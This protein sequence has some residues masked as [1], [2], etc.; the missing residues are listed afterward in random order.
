MSL[1]LYRNKRNFAQTPE[2]AGSDTRQSRKTL[3]FVVQQHH[4]RQMHYD[5]RLELDGVLK[6]WAVPK[7]P[8]MNPHEHH[9]AIMTE[10]HPLAYQK[11]EGEIPEGNYGA[12]KVIIWDAGTY[13]PLHFGGED[14]VRKGIKKGH[15]TFFLHGKKLNGE[16]ALIKF[17]AEK[18]AWLLIKKGDSAATTADITKDDKSIISGV[19]VEDIG[20]GEQLK[21]GKA[22]MPQNVSPML[23]TLVEK[24]LDKPDWLFEIKWDGYRAIGAKDGDNVQLYSRNQ[25][26]FSG[27]FPD[28]VDALHKLKDNVV[29]DGEV[30]V[31]DPQGTPHFEWLQSWHR[32][33]QGT[34]YYYVF[35][36]LWHNG[37]DV[38][39][40]PLTERKKLLRTLINTHSALRYSDHLQNTGT[41]LFEQAQKDGLEG[42]VAK[43]ADSTYQPGVRGNDWLKI[44]THQR[45]EAVIVGFTDP[46]GSRQYIGS[47][48]L[49]V[50]E[51]GKL[52]YVGHSGGGIPPSQLKSLH[53]RLKKLEQK[54]SPLVDPPK[55]GS[56]THWVKP[57]LVCESNFTE[58]TSS[59]QMRHPSFVGLREDK[60]PQKV[61]REL[62]KRNLEG[63][64]AKAA[65]GDTA[66]R[67][68][69]G[70]V[71]FTHLSKVFWPEHGYTKGDLIAYYQTVGKTMLRYLKDRP[72][73]LN[74]QPHGYQDAGFFQKDVNFDLPK[75]AKVKRIYSESTK[76]NVNYLV[77]SNLDT[78]L[79]MAQLG[80]IEINPWNSRLA[81]PDKPDWAVIDLDPEAVSFSQVVKVAQVVGQVCDKWR[82]PAYPK[83][84]GKTGIHIFIPLNA[85]YTYEQARQFA[86]LI[87]TEVN[88]RLPK[89]TSLERS[90]EKRQG[91]VYLDYLQNSRG[92]TLAAAYSARPTKDA[93]VSA[94]LKWS[95]VNENLKPTDF[96]IK[97]MPARLK[98][99]GDLWR[100]VLGRG[101]N[102]AAVIKRIEKAG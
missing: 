59:G 97:N 33:P 98:K 101:V 9:L 24:A 67:V 26:D 22:K 72:E 6:S 96:T 15:L 55:T 51:H 29:L 76:E 7:G 94:P 42:I 99:V 88:N 84:T 17:G 37:R 27:K 68:R 48:V 18:D 16:F 28:V 73:S 46:K 81:K 77:A 62:P 12:G 65:A 54:A 70:K 91:K 57:E 102:I 100:G 52:V 75:F 41:L 34:L 78:L 69:G 30:V 95:E 2:P 80:C 32:Q 36:I 44:K 83:T 90:P 50:Y 31:L 71:D 89:I 21:A 87:A 40:L 8:S 20:H 79:Y 10:D 93:T 92:Q 63:P 74:R 56:D 58:W 14:E 3:R 64:G 5:F 45:Q 82:V 38:S 4:A 43:K 13:E 19:S 85:K 11:F 25:Q 35:D 66:A 60:S 23:C 86:L 49:G 39:N 53:A 1:R 61:H 47:L